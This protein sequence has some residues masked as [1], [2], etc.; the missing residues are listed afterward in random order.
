MKRI[1]FKYKDKYTHGEWR[2]QMCEMESVAQCI[3]MYGLGED[4]EYEIVKV[5]EVK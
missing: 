2:T 1:T 3:E 5:E 4:C